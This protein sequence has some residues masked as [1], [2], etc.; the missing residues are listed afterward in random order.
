MSDQV[1]I[2]ALKDGPYQVSGR[3]GLMDAEGGVQPAEEDPIYL[4][5]CGRSASKP[6]CDGTH[7]KVG[8]EAEGWVRPSTRR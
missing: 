1:T 5:R 6:F 8:F 7:K 4:C 3:P 2:R